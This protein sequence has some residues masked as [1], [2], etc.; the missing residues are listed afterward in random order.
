VAK[1]LLVEDYESLQKIYKAVLEQEGH[2]VDVA[3]DGFVALKKATSEVFDLILL[4]L[5]LPHQ[6]GIE[7]LH[8]FNPKQHPDTKIVVCSNF[9]NAKFTQEASELGVAHCL[10]KSNLSPKEIATVIAN[11]LKEPQ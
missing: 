4:D 5:L 3:N 11:T 7:F 2:K 6:S 1:L 10:T 9:A 8:A